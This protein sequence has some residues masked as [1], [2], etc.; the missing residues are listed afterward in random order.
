MAL[1]PFFTSNQPE[2]M[3]PAKIKYYYQDPLAVEKLSQILASHLQE[4]N[5]EG[6]QPLV[7]VCIGTDRSTGDCLGPLVGTNLLHMPNLPFAVYGTLDEPVHASNL[8]EKLAYIKTNHPDP[9]IIA[10]DACLGQAENVGAITLAPGALK[11]GAGVNKNLPAVGD[12]HFTGIVNVGGY[13]EYFVLQNTRLSIVM[14]MAQQI[15]SSIYQGV[16]LVYKHRNIAVARGL[17]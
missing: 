13:M 5:P 11:P 16:C 9:I 8:T 4:L 3:P 14:R 15:A 7:V 1:L 10:V 17:Q 12:I 2:A 6:K